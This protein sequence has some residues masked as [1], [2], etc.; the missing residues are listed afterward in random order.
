MKIL[1]YCLDIDFGKSILKYHFDKN[2]SLNAPYHNFYHILTVADNCLEACAYYNLDIN[3]EINI[4]VAALFHDFS[5]S[6]G[7]LKD[8]ENIKNAIISFEEWYNDN[9]QYNSLINK[10]NVIDIIKSTE[11]PYV[12]DSK[13]LT[14]EQKIIRDSDLCQMLLDN[15]IQQ[16]YIGLSTE[17]NLSIYDMLKGQEKFINSIIPNTEWFKI[18]FLKNNY[19]LLNEIKKLIK[20]YES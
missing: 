16:V 19:Y 4:I 13:D 17:M 6:M 14:I 10:E 9:N 20:I 15:R 1:D 18:K 8:N 12:I 7:K 2:T 5:H 3:K 11:Y